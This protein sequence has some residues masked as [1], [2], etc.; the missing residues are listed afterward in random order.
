MRFS[1]PLVPTF[2]GRDI[3]GSSSRQFL[4]VSLSYLNTFPPSLLHPEP[5]LTLSQA[6]VNEHVILGKVHDAYTEALWMLE[7]I[8]LES[9]PVFESIIRTKVDEQTIFMCHI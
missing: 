7:M 9:N 3:L 5:S 2:V 8:F 4:K 1:L 6:I